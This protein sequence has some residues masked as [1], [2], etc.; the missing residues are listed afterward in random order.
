M[1]NNP[2]P[3]PGGQNRKFAP[4]ETPPKQTAEDLRSK[5]QLAPHPTGVKKIASLVR[6]KNSASMEEITNIIDPDQMVTQRLI[7]MAYPRA[8]ARIGA[9]VQMATS[10]LGLNRV[11]VVLV[12]DLL[13]HALME[14]FETMVALPMEPCTSSTMTLAEHGYLTGS[15]KF[16]GQATGQVSLTF[17]PHLSL[18]IA[19]RLLG[20]NMED[21][22]LEAI[23]DAIGEL[24]NIITGSLQSKLCDAG[25][26]SEVGLPEV[27]F[28]ASL[29][30]EPV[31]G[32]S[33]DQF[34]FSHG[35]HTLAMTLSIDPSGSR[36]P[37][38]KGTAWRVN[39]PV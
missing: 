17:S 12:G 10:R 32:G 1:H 25:L 30:K 22:D 5:Y 20:G 6:G 23:H 37:S 27:N 18:L 34:F 21:H 8:A 36:A 13:T 7:S 15:V 9:T 33:M 2:P 3:P 35:I 14:T 31:P 11:I 4:S 16:T 26:P 24:V 39:G 28:Q 29:P 38:T 19:T